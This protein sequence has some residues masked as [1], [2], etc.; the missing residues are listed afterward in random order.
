MLKSIQKFFQQAN[1]DNKE[2][3]MKQETKVQP[4]MTVV[5][6]TADLSAQLA[7]ATEAMSAIEAKFAEMSAK[8]EVAQAA[9]AVI[10]ADKASL[11]AEAA[12]KRLASRTEAITMAVG[13][14]KAASLLAATSS[15]DDTQFN[16]IVSAMA[17]SFD[18]E[19]KSPLFQEK[20]VAATADAPEV[21]AVTRLANNIAKQF[22]TK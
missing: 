11:V 16:A 14:A 13:T 18:A 7:S 10:E 17:T 3:V 1:A 20:G 6:D 9:L 21:D 2:V 5:N 4:E 15:L 22:P 8:Y 12:A 19:A